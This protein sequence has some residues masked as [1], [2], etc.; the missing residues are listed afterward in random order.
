M[1]W[2][3]MDEIE[4]IKAWSEE[5]NTETVL[6]KYLPQP[7]S[8]MESYWVKSN[9]E[10]NIMEY[11]FETVPEL[12]DLLKRELTDEFF[13]N[14]ILPLAVAAYKEKAKQ[15]QAEIKREIENTEKNEEKDDGFTIP[16]FVYVF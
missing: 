2:T 8:G 7:D 4:M 3:D 12:S 6:K 16:E 14:L 10:K 13:D 15:E 9:N 5:E 1:R 11:G